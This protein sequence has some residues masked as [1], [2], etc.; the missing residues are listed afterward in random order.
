[1]MHL[2]PKEILAR[3]KEFLQCADYAAQNN[4][5]NGCAISLYAA[6]FWA[7]RAALAY[8]GFDRPTW[9]H[10]ELRSKFAEELIKNRNRYPK[11]F[12]KWLINAF[13]LRN[14]AQYHFDTPQAKKIKRMVNNAKQFIQKI[15][16][17]IN[18]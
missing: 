10:G 7:A 18:K 11:S 1:M 13:V 9:E 14:K 8:E 2:T 17:V 4:Y 3:A 12:S 16:E 15:E 6:L 5:I